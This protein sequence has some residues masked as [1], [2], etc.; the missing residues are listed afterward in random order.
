VEEI[1]DPFIWGT[2]EAS[3]CLRHPLIW[4]TEGVALCLKFRKLRSLV[5]LTAVVC[6]SRQQNDESSDLKQ[7]PLI[8]G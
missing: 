3:L 6:K 7:R 4:G 1:R 5:L 2:E 8:P